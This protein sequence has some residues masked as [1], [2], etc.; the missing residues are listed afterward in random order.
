MQNPLEN[1]CDTASFIIKLQAWGLELYLERDSGLGVFLWFL[2]N[3][4]NTFLQKQNICGLLL[5]RWLISQ[6]I[7]I[8]D[9]RLGSKYAFHM[10]CQPI[11][12]LLFDTNFYRKV[13]SKTRYWNLDFNFNNSTKYFQTS[14]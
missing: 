13:L 6:K 10:R 14:S 11:D 5:R 7:V 9:V 2:L 4:E 3:S 8:V 12:R 1:I